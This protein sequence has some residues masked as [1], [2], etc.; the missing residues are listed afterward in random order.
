MNTEHSPT[1]KPPDK[2]S[3]EELGS[4][5]RQIRRHAKLTQT[6]VATRL[7]VTKQ[8]ISNWEKGINEPTRRHKQLLADLY[9]VTVEG[10]SRR[11][12][13]ILDHPEDKPY[14]RTDVDRLKL[15]EARHSLGLTQQEAG[16][17][18]GLSVKTVY[19]YETGARIPS[20]NA[21]LKMAAA[22]GKPLSWFMKDL[23]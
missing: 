18:A 5:L 2:A 16:A 15:I 19:H 4:R 10:I 3:R 11:Y 7:K 14:R 6:Q 17:Q 12:D 22:Y 9:G 13:F 1:T 20:T 21:M 23:D 8:A